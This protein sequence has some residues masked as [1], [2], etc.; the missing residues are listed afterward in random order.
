MIFINVINEYL[1]II[2]IHLLLRSD[3]IIILLILMKT[4]DYGNCINNLK[5]LLTDQIIL[6]TF[7]I[8]RL[9]L[10]KF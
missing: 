6:L 3:L 9:S 8:A 2:L 1:M 5:D 7:S 10:L 4:D